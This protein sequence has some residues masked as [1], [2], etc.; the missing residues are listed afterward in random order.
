MV[1]LLP[2]DLVAWI[3]SFL[4]IGMISIPSLGQAEISG[5]GPYPVRN[6][7]PLQQIFL[8]MPGDRA[9][10]I[11][12]KSLDIRV[13][14]AETATVFNEQNAV[15]GQLKFETLRAGVFL[16]YGLTKRLELGLE[17]PLLY[18]YEGFLEGA[19][20]AVERATTGLSPARHALENEGFIFNVQKNSRTL[21][22]DGDGS[23]GLGDITIMG[24]F[25]LVDQGISMPAVA[26]RWGLKVPTGEQ[27]KFFGSGHTDF[28][29]GLALEK[30]LGQQWILYS[31]VNGVFPT[32]TV[33]G[34]SLDPIF[35]GIVAIEYLWTPHIS[36]VT[37]FD[38]FSTPYHGTG[39]EFLDQGV[40]ELAGG[41]NVRFARHFVWQVYGVENVDFITGS[42]ADFTL[43]TLLTYQFRAS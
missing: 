38:Y 10:V 27:D 28:G 39:A 9:A 13:E 6:F 29:V 1:S 11:P 15:K 18:R 19:I 32:G 14:L 3:G 8:G 36:L 33:A 21:F 12:K 43:S 34:F 20:T 5:F 4:L 22:A 23:V 35:S 2:K 30:K 7:H 16:R 31:N 26:L 42:S 40:T 24:K 25:L 37:Q 41:F 17:V